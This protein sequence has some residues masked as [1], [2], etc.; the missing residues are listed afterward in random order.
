[1]L[2]PDAVAALTTEAGWPRLVRAV[3]EAELAGHNTGSLLASAI[4]GRQL[5][6]AQQVSDVLR[7]RVQVLAEGRTPEQQVPGGDWTALAPP[8]DGP[9]GQFTHE[10]A[11]LAQGPPARAG[12]GRAR[13]G[14]RGSRSAC[15]TVVMVSPV[16]VARSLTQIGP[17][18]WMASSSESR[19][20][21][22]SSPN[23]SVHVTTLPTSSMAAAA[24]QTR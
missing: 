2:D 5:A 20:G 3:R 15:E 14:R 22:P 17:A 16:A 18:R 8:T 11:V 24:A 4:V 12:P 9:V 10:L 1:M 21:S 6:D 19:V 23:N 7:Y 13:C